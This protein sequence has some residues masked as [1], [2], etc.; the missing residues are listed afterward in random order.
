M[1]EVDFIMVVQ[2]MDVLQDLML[3]H[4]QTFPAS[5]LWLPEMRT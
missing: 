2:I 4:S 1:E 3:S 5:L